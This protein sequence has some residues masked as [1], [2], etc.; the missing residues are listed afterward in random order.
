MSRNRAGR[1]PGTRTN[2]DGLTQRQQQILD[3]IR[4][5]TRQHGFPPSMREIAAAAGLLSTSSVSHQIR[6][7]EKKGVLRQDP[8]RPRAYVLADNGAGTGG[9]GPEGGA[10][11]QA[12]ILGERQAVVVPLVGRIAAGVPITAEELVEDNLVLPAQVVGAGRLFAVTVV[13]DSMRDAH[14]EDGDLVVVRAQ[15][16]ADDGDIVAAMLDGEATVKRLA[17]E[18]PH[19]W[20]KPANPSYEPIPGDEAVILGKVVSV[21]RRL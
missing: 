5:H 12:E 2:E 6:A 21:L 15:D 4:S 1:P 8:Q 10:R 14:I 13:G 19:V 11:S 3:I 7:L 17:H 16:T 9:D 20:L 18:G